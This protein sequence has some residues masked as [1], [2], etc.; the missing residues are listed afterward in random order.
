[1]LRAGPAVGIRAEKAAGEDV[2]RRNQAVK[3]CSPNLPS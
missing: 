2:W 1:V 3:G